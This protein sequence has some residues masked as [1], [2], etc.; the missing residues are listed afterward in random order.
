MRTHSTNRPQKEQS[1]TVGELKQES[2]LPPVYAANCENPI[3]I[4]VKLQINFSK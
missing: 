2:K 3:G 4:D 1:I